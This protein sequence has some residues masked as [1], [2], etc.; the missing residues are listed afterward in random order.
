MA[1]EDGYSNVGGGGSVH[2]EVTTAEDDGEATNGD[3]EKVRSA[4]IIGGP[5]GI[6]RR[7]CSGVDKKHGSHFVLSIYAPAISNL[8]ELTKFLGGQGV[9]TFSEG[10][11]KIRLKIDPERPDQIQVRWPRP[12]AAR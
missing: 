1:D 12:L 4:K 3:G 10:R 6:E 11:V 9:T 7:K 8:D 5:N 2:W